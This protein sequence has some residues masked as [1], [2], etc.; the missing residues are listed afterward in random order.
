[1]QVY[2]PELYEKEFKQIFESGDATK[3]MDLV[4]E[5]L[6]LVTSTATA[7]GLQITDATYNTKDRKIAQDKAKVAGRSKTSSD[8]KTTASTVSQTKKKAEEMLHEAQ[9]AVSTFKSGKFEDK[10]GLD[11]SENHYRKG[12]DADGNFYEDENILSV[13]GLIGQYDKELPA[14]E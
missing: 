10:E 14:W 11:Y 3:I 2:Q 4:R 9:K 1:M 6:A 5:G 8:V 7:K 12:Y 13:T